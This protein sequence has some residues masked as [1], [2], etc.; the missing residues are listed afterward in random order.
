MSRTY[1]Q[2]ILVPVDLSEPSRAGL[3]VANDL[4]NRF[5]ASLT[6]LMVENI[7]G[8]TICDAG[9]A[10]EH[11]EAA[12][13][14][15]LETTRNYLDRFVRKA[16]G[17][18]HDRTVDIVDAVF[19]AD[20]I[21]R[22]ARQIKADW[23]CI[24][25]A[26]RRGWKQFFLGSVTADVVCHSPLPVLTFR[27]RASDDVAY[28]FDDFRRV[29]VATDLDAGCEELVEFG[30]TLAGPRGELVL[31]HVLESPPAYDTYGV[32]LHVGPSEIELATQH[33]ADALRRLSTRVE[34]SILRPAR[35]EVG[36][37]ADRILA[38]DRELQPDVIV[39]GTHG[40]TGW[41]HLMLGSVAERV[42][43]YATGPVLVV[44][45]GSEQVRSGRDAFADELRRRES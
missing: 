14:D 28:M 45:T 29:L 34:P 3:R 25:T 38:L 2:H 4:A 33:A 15:R 8:D 13:A 32:K 23:I 27:D 43:R 5:D 19:F 44:P 30:A 31:A 16:I 20:A 24:S 1:P 11:L 37:P 18:E 7:T 41:N 6:V 36:R 12:R 10:P 26:G 17:Q 42:I 21:L 22:H 9:H 35:T 39:M 40:R